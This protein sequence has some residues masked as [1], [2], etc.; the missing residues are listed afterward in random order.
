MEQKTLTDSKDIP[1]I[2]REALLS[3]VEWVKIRRQ[4]DER[5]ISGDSGDQTEHS[6]GSQTTDHCCVKS[7]D[8]SQTTR[9]EQP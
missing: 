7:D 2:G 1:I 4:Q 9:N 8:R 5:A 3:L 6:G